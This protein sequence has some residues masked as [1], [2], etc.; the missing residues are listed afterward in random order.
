[1][2][3]F[4]DQPHPRTTTT[5][6]PSSP[7]APWP[8]GHGHYAG[9]SIPGSGGPGGLIA[10]KIKGDM[11][12]PL[13]VGAA[14]VYDT[15]VGTPSP[16]N[17]LTQSPLS[18]FTPLPL[19]SPTSAPTSRGTAYQGLG[20]DYPGT[21]ASSWHDV[22]SSA[23]PSGRPVM[24][25]FLQQEFAG[26]GTSAHTLRSVRTRFGDVYAAYELC[27]NRTGG[28]WVCQ[29]GSTFVRDS[30]WERHAV[31]SL[32]HSAGGGF[33]CSICDISFTR[34][35]AMFRHRRKKHGGLNTSSQEAEGAKG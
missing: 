12:S 28:R 2:S 6:P 15:A 22:L 35:D 24:P 34:S 4:P 31:H 17:C 9:T 11:F 33:D 26:Q 21:V 18:A 13:S 7:P 27:T 1:V 14:P 16:D 3:V 5:G 20:Y 25:P 32:S 10:C 30:D 8:K 29:C 23:E 19:P